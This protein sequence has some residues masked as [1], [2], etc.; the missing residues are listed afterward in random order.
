[1]TELA[2]KL[3]LLDAILLLVGGVIGSGVFLTAGQIAS[4]V[5]RADLFILVWVAG[6]VISLRP[7]LSVAE[8]G[9]M[10]PTAGSQYVFLREAYGDLPAFLYVWV[11]FSLGQTAAIASIAVGFAQ[12]LTVLVPTVAGRQKLCAVLGIA[13]LT[14]INVFGVKKGARLINVAT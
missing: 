8:L 4:S 2:K 12:Y 14:A 1:M 11:I 5:K 9:G 6:G 10:F 13:V 7:W 3:T